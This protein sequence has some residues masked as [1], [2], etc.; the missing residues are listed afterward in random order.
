LL[1]AEQMAVDAARA[2]DDKKATEVR[3]MDMRDTLGITD[4][5]VLASGRND[6]QVKRI[7]DAIEEK[8][9]EQGVKPARREGERFGRWVLLDY[10][11][12]VVHIF[13]D[14]EREF[15]SLER[16]WGNVPLVEWREEKVT[17]ADA[18]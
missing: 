8:L 18:P 14:E 17:E 9:R 1:T 10:I 12:F 11:D 13:L 3:I 5:F 7:R 4:Y 6:R 15:Y 16:L 2:A